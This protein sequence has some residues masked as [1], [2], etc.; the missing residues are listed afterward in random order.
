MNGIGMS[1]ELLQRLAGSLL[2][3]IWQ[4]AL[5]ALIS[6]VTLRLMARSS[7]ASRYIAAVAGM[8]LMA[9]APVVTFVFYAETGGAT[10]RALQLLRASV[11]DMAHSGA[12][13]GALKWATW[14]VIIWTLGVGFCSTRLIA[15]W[16]LSRRIIRAAKEA[17]PPMVTML[18]ERVRRELLERRTIRILVGTRVDTPVV[19]GWIRPIVLL[20]ATA[21][22]GLPEDQLLAVLAHELAHIRRHDFLVNS[23]Q[24]AVECV[25][26]Y[27][28]AVWW[29]SG[30]IRV[31]RELCCDDLAVRVCGDNLVYARALITLEK[32]RGENA[33]ALAIPAV[34]NGVTDRIR[35]VLGLQSSARDWQSAA[36][37]LLFLAILAGA[38]TWRPAFAKQSQIP[39]TPISIPSV[40]QQ[41]KPLV[42]PPTSKATTKQPL[43]AIA[44]VREE[45]NPTLNAIVAIA[46]AQDVV[47]VPVPVPVPAPPVNPEQGSIRGQVRDSN[48][49]LV[50]RGV[51]VRAT[52]VPSQASPQGRGRGGGGGV[53]REIDSQGRYEL[54]VLP[55]SYTISI[56]DYYGGFPGSQ[57]PPTFVAV[58]DK[59]GVTNLDL[60]FPFPLV[61]A[62]K[63]VQLQGRVL[64]DDDSGLPVGTLRRFQVVLTSAS[65]SEATQPFTNTQGIFNFPAIPGEYGVKV[66]LGLG[67]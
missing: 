2:H 33:P 45:A 39:S 11:T 7:A 37:A 9:A 31:E 67:Y 16:F 53:G 17:V 63:P 27:H 3:F 48:G 56:E 41:S 61:P 30:R 44:P 32:T 5:L 14:I 36:V 1:P 13:P 42:A 54:N 21:V 66:A 4:G 26:F 35:S 10:L 34:G 15:G 65:T 40:A 64:L 55:G 20:P 50:S 59:Q 47:G 12:G 29:I 24:R 6:I 58:V 46:T 23:L 57:V 43:N 19:F 51:W 18:L 25:L 62:I 22:T 8:T 49:A 52:Q 38:G 28:P 60:N